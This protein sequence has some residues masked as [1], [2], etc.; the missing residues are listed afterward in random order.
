MTGGGVP[1]YLIALGWGF[2]AVVVLF[3]I[4]S[5][6]LVIAGLIHAILTNPA[7]GKTDD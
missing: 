1:E 5:V 2:V 3:W 6:P 4:I 7:A